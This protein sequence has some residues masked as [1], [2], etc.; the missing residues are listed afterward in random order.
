MIAFFLIPSADNA[1]R[2]N[3]E[4]V[5]SEKQAGVYGPSLPTAMVTGAERENASSVLVG[6]DAVVE[7]HY[8][9]AAKGAECYHESDCKFAYASSQKITVY[10]AY[11]LG[12]KPC[13]RCNPPTY[14]PGSATVVEQPEG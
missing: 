13:G 6:V 2:G 9:Y 11:Y 7:P 5:G 3:I 10:E 8:V 1:V 14:T 4:L 12:Y